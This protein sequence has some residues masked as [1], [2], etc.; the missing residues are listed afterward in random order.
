MAPFLW[1]SHL[2]PVGPAVMVAL[3]GIATVF[4]VYWVGRDFFGEKAGLVA[5][6]LYTVSPLVIG[7][8]RSSWNPNPLPFFS[9]L[10]MFTLYKALAKKSLRVFFLVGFFFGIALQLHYIATFLGVVV[11]LYTFI[12]FRKTISYL[13]KTYLVAFF[14]FLTGLSPFLAFE[15]KHGF[16]NSRAVI[17][18][19]AGGTGETSFTNGKFLS[20][21]VDVLFRIF[22]RLLTRFPPLEQITLRVDTLQ[23]TSYGLNFKI[24]LVFLYIITLCLLFGSL[25][26]LVYQFRQSRQ[27]NDGGSDKFLLL[28]VWLTVGVSLFGF[29]KKPIYDYYF[30]FLFPLP[31]LLVGNLLSSL[32]ANKKKSLRIGG[33]I[34]FIC[35]LLLNFDGRPMKYQ[36]N[37]QL[38]QVRNISEFILEKAQHKPFN[39]ALITQQ[40]SDHAYR[41]FFELE[42]NSPVVIENTQK[43]PQRK[44]VT[45]VLYII[46]EDTTCKPLGNPLWEVA[47]FGRA[48]IADEWDVSV[49]KVYKLVHFK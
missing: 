9:L 22:G 31:F 33:I 35:L 45:D 4:L 2:D 43:D 42:G 18:F 7:Y 21:L 23:I 48:A 36:P 8:S 46:C 17:G 26:F 37:R 47:G 15:V 19:M 34:V 44:T 40:N 6:S 12:S 39:F 27:R 20:I 24:P 30:G 38:A 16:P 14:G 1:L 29:Y 3:F 10:I 41:Y 25:S 11:V 28:L 5:A 49:V 32:Y 13:G